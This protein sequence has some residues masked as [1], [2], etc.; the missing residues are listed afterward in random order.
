MKA[1]SKKAEWQLKMIMGNIDTAEKLNAK[2][3]QMD[4]ERGRI[5]KDM[6][7]IIRL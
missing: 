6:D 3:Q 2:I 4:A 1:N 5:M 7:G